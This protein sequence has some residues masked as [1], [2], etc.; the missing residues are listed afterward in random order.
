M[1]KQIADKLVENSIEI[2][3]DPITSGYPLLRNKLQSAR[4]GADCR[5]APSAP[6]K[7]L[8]IVISFLLGGILSFG[9]IFVKELFNNK[10][11]TTA[12]HGEVLGHQRDRGR[13]RNDQGTEVGGLDG[14]FRI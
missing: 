12:R 10:F 5:L 2:A 7:M 11:Q 3:N 9:I 6:N 4:R 8:N 14:I 13:S 1:A